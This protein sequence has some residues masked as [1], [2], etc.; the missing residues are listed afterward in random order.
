[1]AGLVGG[2]TLAPSRTQALERVQMRLP[3]LETD[4]TVELNELSNPANLL[5][6]NS[7]LAELDRATDGAVGRK[8][9]ELFN[10]PLPLQV[11]AVVDTSASSP[12]LNQALLLVSALGGIDGLPEPFTGEDL[13]RVLDQAAAKGPLTMLTVLR[14]LLGR[15][16]GRC[17]PCSGWHASSGLRTRCW[18]R[19][20]LLGRILPCADKAHWPC[21]ALS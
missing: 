11:T 10:A 3:L 13:S 2:L 14:A 12:L 6:G 21:S 16:A 1:V 8:F 5:A 9:V 15:T 17:S 20:Q 7:D 18:R 4:F 19:G